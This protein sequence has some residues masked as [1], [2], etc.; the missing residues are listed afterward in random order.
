MKH[1]KVERIC[2]DPDNHSQTH[3]VHR[4]SVTQWTSWFILTTIKVA[5]EVQCLWVSSNVTTKGI[6]SFAFR[7]T[8]SLQN[9]FLERWESNNYIIITLGKIINE[10]NNR[11]RMRTINCVTSAHCSCLLLFS[12]D[13]GKKVRK[14]KFAVFLVKLATMNA[15]NASDTHWEGFKYLPLAQAWKHY[16]PA[17][18]DKT[19]KNLLAKHKQQHVT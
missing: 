2:G 3:S 13:G 6:I 17:S 9:I 19:H 7:K 10:I 11:K 15:S 12:E 14:I 18:T 8:A 1:F 5:A 16:A 4:Y